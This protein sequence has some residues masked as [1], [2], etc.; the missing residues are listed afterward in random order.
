MFLE[1]IILNAHAK[2]LLDGLEDNEAKQA[3][4]AILSPELETLLIS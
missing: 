3:V 2:N 4:L 1:V